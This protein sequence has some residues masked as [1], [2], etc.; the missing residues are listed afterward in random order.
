MEDR[1]RW[2]MWEP[3]LLVLSDVWRAPGVSAKAG[4]LR[5][6]RLVTM[7]GIMIATAK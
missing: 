2:L 5:S 3:A 7:H 6:S 4:W 1:R